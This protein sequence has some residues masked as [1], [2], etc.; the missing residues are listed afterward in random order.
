MLSC[1]DEVPRPIQVISLSRLFVQ[2]ALK[3]CSPPPHLLCSNGNAGTHCRDVT[4][5]SHSYAARF[6]KKIGEAAGAAANAAAAGN[7]KQ[8]V[9]LAAPKEHQ[10]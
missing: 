4:C 2:P 9:D 1:E 8:L 3:D 6:S 5:S 10:A 7:G